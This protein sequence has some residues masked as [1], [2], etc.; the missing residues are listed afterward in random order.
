MRRSP[1]LLGER[2]VAGAVGFDVDYQVPTGRWEIFRQGPG[3]WPPGARFHVLVSPRQVF[4]CAGPLF[5]DG[6]E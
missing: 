6:F 2:V 3:T 1:E 5:R 4:E